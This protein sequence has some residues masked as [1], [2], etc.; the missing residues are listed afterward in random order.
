MVHIREVVGSSPIAPTKTTVSTKEQWFCFLGKQ[1][2]LIFP[3]D[4]IMSP[5]MGLHHLSDLLNILKA[6]QYRG[7]R[8]V[9]QSLWI[10]ETAASW[11]SRFDTAPI[12]NG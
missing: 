5:G 1:F 10:I 4:L 9:I 11:N 12:R 2:N 8:L 7:R 3:E 6:S